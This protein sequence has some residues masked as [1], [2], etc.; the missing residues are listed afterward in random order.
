MLRD[1]EERDKKRREKDQMREKEKQEKQERENEQKKKALKEQ[2]EKL[3]GR[4]LI[5]LKNIDANDTPKEYSLA[6]IKLH[7]KL[8]RLV[9]DKVKYNTTL[10]SLHLSRKGLKDVVGEELA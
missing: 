9:I 7:D 1:K 4:M 6:G 8:S 10:T 2:S 5:M 3:E